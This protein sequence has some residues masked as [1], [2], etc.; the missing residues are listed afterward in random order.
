M[1]IALKPPL[2]V[3]IAD[4]I[5]QEPKLLEA[6]ETASQQL[7]DYLHD[8]K[9]EFERYEIHWSRNRRAP[10]EISA[11]YTEWDDYGERE[12]KVSIPVSRL[13]DPVLRNSA[14]INLR[15]EAHRQLFRQIDKSMDKKMAILLEEERQN[16]LQ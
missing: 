13:Y 8:E 16:G 5:R 14:L 12:A 15:L 3:V 1:A 11:D 9:F 2:T 7:E 4:E 6:V 10:N